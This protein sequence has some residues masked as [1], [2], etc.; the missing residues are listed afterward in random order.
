MSRLF[1]F[2]QYRGRH[3]ASGSRGLPLGGSTVQEQA[4]FAAMAGDGSNGKQL[5]LLA[6]NSVIKLLGGIANG[7]FGFALVVVVARFLHSRG[8]GAY[9]EGIA[10]YSLAISFALAGADSGLVRMIPR[11]RATGRTGDLRSLVWIAL[12]PVVV[13][14]TVMAVV[15]FVNAPALGRLLSHHGRSAHLVTTY[16]RVL[17]PFIPLGAAS[18]VALSGTR[19]FNTMVPL[20]AV[21]NVGKPGLRPVLTVAAVVLG[22]GAV[23]VGLAWAAPIAA[24]LVIAL[25]WLLILLRRAER[26]D[27]GPD[28]APRPARELASEFW[29]FSAPTAVAQVF[30]RAILWLDTLLIGA[31]A[32]TADAGVYTATTRYILP[33]LVVMQGLIVSISPQISGLISRGQHDEA[34]QI[35]RVSTWWV[36]VVSWPFYLTLIVWAPLLLRVLGHDFESGQTT[37]LILSFAVL[38]SMAAGPVANVLLMAGHNMWNMVNSMVALALNIALNFILIP[39]FGITGAAIAWMVSIVVSNVAALVEL[40][41]LEALDPFGSGFGAAVVA[42]SACFG[43]FGLI[44]RLALGPH[45]FAFVLFGVIATA[46]YALVL[47]KIRGFL[48]VSELREAVRPRTLRAAVRTSAVPPPA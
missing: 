13:V 6:N 29:R 10:L 23:A 15:L 37:M 24:G 26:R 42:S 40:G 7:V 36:I 46:V 14:G 16:I 21:D 19:G 9:F 48:H 27:G 22:L 44:V 1:R 20:I 17:V 35:Y 8:S 3:S 30:Q 2:R 18:T 43:I 11:Y 31:L 28:V 4:G 34:K 5:T 33:G 45:L 12:I 38:V 39:R 47:R 41:V 32:S 25:A